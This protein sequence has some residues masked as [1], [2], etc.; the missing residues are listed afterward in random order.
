MAFELEKFVTDMREAAASAQPVPA[1]NTLMRKAVAEPLAV[2]AAMPDYDGDELLLHEDDTVSIFCVQFYA[3]RI[4]PPHNHKMP[5]FIGVYQG[6]EIN[7]LY[8]HED[9]QLKLIKE[10]AV[11]AGKTLS[12]GAAGI[13]GVRT[14]SPSEDSYALH[15]YLGR[16]NGVERELFDPVTGAAAPFTKERFDALVQIRSS[17]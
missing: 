11:E 12:I 4:V 13:H 9:G 10:Q 1:V 14:G 17:T 8:R 6:T 15:V 2:A 16:L 3:D 5:A 7:E